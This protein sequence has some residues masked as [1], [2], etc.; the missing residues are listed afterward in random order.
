MGENNLKINT[1]IQFLYSY[2]Q[3]PGL[4]ILKVMVI[5]I[6]K[7]L[8]FKTSLNDKLINYTVEFEFA[9]TKINSVSRLKQLDWLSKQD[10]INNDFSL[11]SYD[12][13]FNYSNFHKTF[14]KYFEIVLFL[15]FAN[16]YL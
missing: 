13:Y 14:C 5:P 7:G 3:V 9:F 16:K 8:A 1:G 10:K 6:T 2:R 15:F 11:I 4:I 12:E